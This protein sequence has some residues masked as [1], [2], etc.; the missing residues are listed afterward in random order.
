MNP[1][2][3]KKK[4]R[5]TLKAVIESV[6]AESGREF[7]LH[8]CDRKEDLDEVVD[9]AIA[10]GYQLIFAVGGDGTVREIGTRLIGKP[11]VLG[12]LPAGSGNGLARHLQISLDP[13]AALRAIPGSRVEA[14]DT[15]VVNNMPFLNVAGVGFDALIA[16]RFAAST[17]RGL[18]TYVR[19]GI[20]LYATYAAELYEIEVDGE[21]LKEAAFL[22]AVANASQYGSGAQI[23]PLASLQDG[24]LDVAL[25]QTG[26]W[27]AVPALLQQ[28]FTGHI[29]ESVHVINRKGREIRIQR[30]AAGPAH[31]DGEPATL[32]AT[33]HFSIL[34]RSL[35]V[36]V[37]PSKSPL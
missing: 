29:H 14:I 8:R 4:T 5:D 31:I 22:I 21:V 34:P 9:G 19:E 12:V 24:L 35:R 3:G 25:L 23:A 33:L 10:K 6:Y 1:T 26:T 16:E 15:A 17:V 28:L 13:A 18:E 11:A 7:S 32:P 27:T 2:S 30:R 37:P 20:K 36:L